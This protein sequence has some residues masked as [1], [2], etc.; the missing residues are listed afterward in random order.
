ME[1]QDIP[2]EELT[3]PVFHSFAD[4]WFILTAGEYDRGRFN[5]MTV[6]WGGLGTI[7]DRPVAMVVV[8]PTR[9]TYQFME[10][11]DTFTLCA[12]AEQHRKILSWCGS[13]SGREGD[14]VRGSGL[15]PVASRTVK[16]PGYEQAELI[17]ECRK[18]YFNDLV[19][20]NFLDESIEKHYPAKDYHRMYLGQILA[21]SGTREY[22]KGK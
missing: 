20:R 16:A 2:L 3:L 18:I 19:P 10:R 4:R 5:P 17:L 22:R 15:L 6:S 7:W 21:A 12:F 11:Y 1:R 8:R 9:H 14:K 13:R